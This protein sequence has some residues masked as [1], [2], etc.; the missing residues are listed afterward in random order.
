MPDFLSRFQVALNVS[1]GNDENAVFSRRD[2]HGD[3]WGLRRQRHFCAHSQQGHHQARN[4]TEGYLSGRSV[5]GFSP[6]SGSFLFAP[7][8]S[9]P[10]TRVSTPS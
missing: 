4:K 1:L 5:T 8:A 7:P 2:G 3:S 9:S 6:G 10:A